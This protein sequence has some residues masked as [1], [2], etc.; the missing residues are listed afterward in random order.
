M[1]F[2]TLYRAWFDFVNDN[3]SIVTAN[4]TALYCSILNRWNR[5]GQKGEFGLPTESGIECSGIKT[6]NT[7][8]KCLAE[9]CE[10]GFVALKSVSINQHTSR[11]ISLVPGQADH[12][13]ST[14]DRTILND[15]ANPGD[16][17]NSDVAGI[18]PD[19]NQ[20][21]QKANNNPSGKNAA[22][23]AENKQPSKQNTHNKQTNQLTNQPTNQLCR[24]QDYRDGKK[25]D[26]S[27]TNEKISEIFRYWAEKIEIKDHSR[28]DTRGIHVYLLSVT[29][30][31]FDH[32]PKGSR[33][34]LP[35]E[36][37]EPETRENGLIPDFPKLR[38]SRN[39]SG[40]GNKKRQG[41]GQGAF[42]GN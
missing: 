14:F 13:L 10:W 39:V 31:L 25:I 37:M 8:S 32:R 5:L 29:G 28:T 6:R 4:H 40:Y 20:Y 41:G 19:Q 11:V 15:N 12:V 1:D 3:P 17:T 24:S 33:G 16:A 23:Q 22:I 2:F 26:G 21:K 18:P 42:F 27:T 7:F 9:L 38:K 30:R 34:R 35:S 36:P